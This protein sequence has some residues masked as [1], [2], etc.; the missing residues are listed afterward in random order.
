MFI[1]IRK[2]HGIRQIDELNR[3]VQQEFVPI[4]KEIPGLKGYHTVDCGG[5]TV[6]SISLF[7]S[8]EQALASNDK[9]REWVQS[10][11]TDLITDPPEI[12]AGPT[13]VDVP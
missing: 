11:L 13:G 9:A 2:Y 6:V 10:R 5:G 1:S 4:L 7:D 3:R 12:L 8:R